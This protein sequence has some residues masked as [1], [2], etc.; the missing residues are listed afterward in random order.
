MNGSNIFIIIPVYNEAT[1]IAQTLHQVLQTG[2][3]VVVVDDGSTDGT[4]DVV[5]Q[6][7][8]HYILHPVNIGQ[9][10]A[11]QT[12]MDFARLRNA[13]AVVH[14]DADGQHRVSDIDALLQPVLTGDCDVA[15]GSRFFYKTDKKIPFSKKMFLQI[16]R[17]VNWMFT[18]ILLTDAHNGLRALNKK[19]LDVIYFSE[20]RMAHA[21]EMLSIIKEKKLT[22]REVPVT[23]EYT[24]YS[25]R[26][27]QSLWNSINIIF[28]L[29]FKKIN[30]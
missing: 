10:A 12:G 9:G 15:L 30:R 14:F 1:V 11:L 23:I 7:P 4:S 6:F 28:D 2:H 26:K 8:V 29:L 16:A 13:N 25:M 19:A 27:G 24:D 18:G 5:R 3:H 17:Y 22:Y 20:N 21:S